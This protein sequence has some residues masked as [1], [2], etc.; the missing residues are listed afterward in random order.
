M[1]DRRERKGGRERQR[2]IAIVAVMKD[3]FIIVLY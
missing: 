2:M 3:F 1:N